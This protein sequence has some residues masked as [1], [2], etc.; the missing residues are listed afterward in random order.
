MQSQIYIE[1]SESGVEG[2]LYSRCVVA[3]RV[4]REK[5]EATVGGGVRVAS[6]GGWAGPSLHDN[7]A[8]GFSLA[9]KGDP[10]G[11]R[12]RACLVGVR[13]PTWPAMGFRLLRWGW[14]EYV[15]AL[16]QV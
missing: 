7:V 12:Y 15:F 16:R 14:K 13:C 4:G 2:T 9:T 11:S 8:R 5:R 10:K 1:R 6:K 3:L